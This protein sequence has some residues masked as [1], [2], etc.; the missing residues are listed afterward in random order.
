MKLFGWLPILA[1]LCGAVG[2]QADPAPGQP[3]SLSVWLARAQAASRQRAYT[4]TFVVSAGAEMSTAKIWHV[5]DGTNQ[6]ERVETLTGVPRSTFRRNDQVLTMYPATKVAVAEQRELFGQF[7]NILQTADDSTAEHYTLKAMGNERVV[8]IDAEVVQLIPRD[9]SRFGYRVW[10]ERKS[11]LVL[12]LQVLDSDGRVLEQSAFSE[13]QLDAPVSMQR[14]S[15]MMAATDGYRMEQRAVRKVDAQ[16]L[17]W[18]LRNV[19]P[20]FRP[21]GCYQRALQAGAAV[22]GSSQEGTLQWLFSDGLATVS[23]FIDGYD[24]RRHLKEGAVELG[25]ATRSVSRRFGEW[26]IT[27]VGE[28]PVPTLTAFAQSLERR[29]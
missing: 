4:G 6:M 28:A 15:A 18:S 25:G 14:L 22:G 26:W 29:K 3:A 20:G 17:G 8:G 13:L 24:A 5:C 7:P 23:M 16:E 11:G 19:V 2:V 10:S 21:V 12:R 27:V 1:L 9:G